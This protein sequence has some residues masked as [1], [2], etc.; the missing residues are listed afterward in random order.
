MSKWL[1]TC[2]TEAAVRE[3]N[4]AWLLYASQPHADDFRSKACT[5]DGQRPAYALARALQYA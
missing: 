3:I 1:L 5:V 4:E 2:H